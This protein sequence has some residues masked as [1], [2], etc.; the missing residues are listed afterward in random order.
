MPAG[1]IAKPST[2]KR[3]LAH[4]LLILALWLIFYGSFTLITPALLDDA[5]SVHAEVAREMLLRHDYVTLYANSIRYLEKAPLLYW[6]MAACMR[7]SQLLGHTSAAALA[8]AARIPLA[9]TVLALAFL[10]E[11]FTRRIFHTSAHD[12]IK[13]EQ[14]KIATRA[15]LYAALILLSSFGLFLFTRILIPDALLTLTLTAALYAFHLTEHPQFRVPHSSQSHRDGWDVQTPHLPCLLFAACCAL[16]VLTKGLIGLLFPIAIVLTYLLLTRGPRATLQRLRQLHPLSSLAVFTAIAAPW[17]ILIALANPTQGHPANLTFT[18]HHWQVPLPTDGNVHGWAWFY[19]LNEHL[20]RYLNLRVPHDYDTVPLTLF[21]GLILIWLMPWSIFLPQALTQSIRSAAAAI[22]ATASSC[23]LKA[24]QLTARDSSSSQTPHSSQP[25]HEASNLRVPHSSQSHRDEWGPQPQTHLLLL[26]WAAIPL[27]FFSFSTRQE[28]YVLPALPPLAILIAIWLAKDSQMAIVFSQAPGPR[29]GT[30]LSQASLDSVG[31]QNPDPQSI[32]GPFNIRVEGGC[33]RAALVLLTLGTLFAAATTWFLLHTHTPPPNTD[34]STLLQQNPN[35]YAMS[36][37]HFLDL[38]ANALALFRLPLALAALAL[39]LGPLASY[40]LRRRA[41]TQT[42][43]HTKSHTNPSL[44]H[45]ANL[46][47]AASAFLFLFAAH[48]GL[49]TFA[50]ILTSQQLAAAIAPQLTPR[51]GEPP[52]LLVIH[53]EYEYASTL[54]FYLQRPTYT[55]LPSTVSA[56]PQNHT[57]ASAKS[58]PTA[59]S[60]LVATPT[61]PA[62]VS[63]PLGTPRLQPWASQATKE[64]GALA[65]G[66][67]THPTPE[68]PIHIL[69]DPTHNNTPNYGRSSNL[70]YG[71]YFPDAPPIFETTQ[72]LTAKWHSPQRIFL[73][74]DLANEPSPPPPTLTPIYVIAS[75]GGK[76]ILSNQPN[77]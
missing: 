36:L 47:L 63:K 13:P 45:A 19:F 39:F 65:P 6:A 7:L 69:T 72:S 64:N 43:I 57:A 27:L 12:G 15:G 35:D 2:P 23:Q 46:T 30:P 50:P 44:H 68:N 41:H 31:L 18:H 17:H 58:T 60:A 52:P 38:N 77:H 28:Y 32:R 75:S 3:P 37:G 62:T 24:P 34:L 25:H 53:Q 70:W 14:E 76:A 49:R 10:A 5:D 40:L 21:L 1:S 71:S 20:L 67:S 51:P 4:T 56:T 42:Q 11:S 8:T 29:E 33:K 66:A 26:L 54:A 22:A 59:K 73:W 61:P 9:L 55:L 48:L 74:Q 16:A